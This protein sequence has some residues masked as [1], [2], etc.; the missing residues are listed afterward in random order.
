MRRTDEMTCGETQK[1][2]GPAIISSSH[3]LQSVCKVESG[4]NAYTRILTSARIKIPVH[5]VLE[6]STIADVDAG[7]GA[8]SALANRHLNFLPRCRILCLFQ[9]PI[10]TFLNQCGEGLIL[11]RRLGLSLFQQTLFQPNRSP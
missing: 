8:P 1:G 7:P 11:P 2:S 9:H 10:Q 4:R 5:D 6:F 3:D